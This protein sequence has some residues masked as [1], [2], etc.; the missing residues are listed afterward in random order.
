M[1]KADKKPKK[2]IFKTKQSIS[3]IIDLDGYAMFGTR[4][5]SIFFS[6]KDHLIVCG[7]IHEKSVDQLV[8]DGKGN[9]WSIG[10]NVAKKWSKSVLIKA[11]A[12]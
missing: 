12:T 9:I 1:K 6:T 8:N 5:G 11:L 10:G 3:C 4:E 7:N 2:N